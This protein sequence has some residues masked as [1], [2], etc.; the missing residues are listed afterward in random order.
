[1][2]YLS[3]YKAAIGSFERA[4][5]FSSD[6]KNNWYAH[7][8]GLTISL[9]SNPSFLAFYGLSISYFR[10]KE[11]KSAF[12]YFQAFMFSPDLYKSIWIILTS[13]L[14]G[15][16][17]RR[18]RFEELGDNISGWLRTLGLKK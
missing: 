11:I 14:L 1:M 8:I 12:R 17:E 10:L 7:Y 6:R 2:Y 9:S 15:I 4:A 16:R 5:H 3:D 13:L 18:V